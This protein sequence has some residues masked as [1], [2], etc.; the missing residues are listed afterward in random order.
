[1]TDD[2][3]ILIG[4]VLTHNFVLIQFLGVSPIVSDSR[5]PAS[6][7]SLA[8][9]TAIVLTLSS[10]GAYLANAYLLAPLGLE[11]LRTITLILVIVG[12][13]HGVA[14]ALRRANPPLHEALGMFLPLIATNC[15]VLGVALL[16]VRAAQGFMDSLL[17]GLGAG[18]GFALVLLL[19]AGMR[20]RIAEGEIPPA[21]RGAPIVLI[22]AGIM[23]LA[24]MG[25][26][27]IG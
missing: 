20:G 3:L 21:F 11:Y 6:A 17:T 7:A 23:S 8:L 18:L 10:V 1:M 25:F 5:N 16:N 9:A 24:F 2:L 19:F 12:V 27:G 4:A 14:W 13:V 22:T 26:A 15:I